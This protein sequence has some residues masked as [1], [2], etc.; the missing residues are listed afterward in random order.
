MVVIVETV[1]SGFYSSLIQVLTFPAC[2]R[3][4][5]ALKSVF[6]N[7]FIIVLEAI[8]KCYDLVVK[9]AGS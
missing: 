9:P 2:V 4:Y 3:D 5:S 7:F 6:L 1:F 8:P